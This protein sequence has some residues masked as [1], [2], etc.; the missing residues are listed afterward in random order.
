MSVLT[1]LLF[2]ITAAPFHHWGPDVYDGVPTIVTIVGTP[3]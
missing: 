2:K 3:S 1:G